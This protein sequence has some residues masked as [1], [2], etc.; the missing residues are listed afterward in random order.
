M[1]GRKSKI[2]IQNNSENHG[3]IIGENHGTVNV[4]LDEQG[5]ADLLGQQL[6]DF[7]GDPLRELGLSRELFQDFHDCKRLIFSITQAVQYDESTQSSCMD[8]VLLPLLKAVLGMG[9]YSEFE[10]TDFL[11]KL[12]TVHKNND[13]L[14]F[15][16]YRWRALEKLFAGKRE[17]AISDLNQIYSN[18]E[19]SKTVPEWL[20]VNVLIDIR[21]LTNMWRESE[22]YFEVQNKIKAS[23]EDVHFPALDRFDSVANSYLVSWY[24]KETSASPYSVTYGGGTRTTEVSDS[25]FK[26]FV[27]SAFF[28]SITHLWQVNTKIKKV[29]FFLNTK[30]HDGDL[31]SDYLRA[32]FVGWDNEDKNILQNVFREHFSLITF[33]KVREIWC[34]MDFAS[35]SETVA[36]VYKLT[37]MQYLGNYMDD[38]TFTEASEGCFGLI[39]AYVKTGKP[40][41]DIQNAVFEFVQQNIQ[42]VDVDKAIEV[43][44]KDFAANPDYM[45]TLSIGPVFYANFA[46]ISDDSFELLCNFIRNSKAHWNSRVEYFAA[47]LRLSIESSRYA[48]LDELINEV[49]PTFYVGGYSYNFVQNSKSAENIINEQLLF[50]VAIQKEKALTGVAMTSNDHI[51]FDALRNILTTMGDSLSNVQV[52]KICFAIE[53]GLLDH[54]GLETKVCALEVLSILCIKHKDESVTH[55][56]NQLMFRNEVI[57]ARGNSGEWVSMSVF[58]G[59]FKAFSGNITPL[60]FTFILS[61][62][63]HLPV[64][65]KVRFFRYIDFI[66]KHISFTQDSGLMLILL[67]LLIEGISSPERDVRHYSI[68]ALTKIGVNNLNVGNMVIEL[69]YKEYAGLENSVNK[70]Y[71]I[72]GMAK[73][74]KSHELTVKILNDTKLGNNY[75]LSLLTDRPQYKSE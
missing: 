49:S 8:G 38:L 2:E 11:S 55:L 46:N 66:C 27:A 75:E 6:R 26:S 30:W 25:I 13:V 9:K 12:D 3:A 72:D 21:N 29:L 18:Y 43:I 44:F 57:K 45:S 17:Q 20:K 71:I 53:K 41:F 48:V 73:I 24:M 15:V 65:M 61:E 68:K 40:L 54:Y 14:N 64:S 1:L 74:N 37:A 36:I 7:F 35:Y 58:F 5:T 56:A 52:E 59:L 62:V 39:N 63:N 70:S 51:P 4:G 60:E 33:D 67:Q 47:R 69:M 28:G 31:F 10:L 23:H 16:K 19:T 22:K 34:N 50:A 32:C 42:R